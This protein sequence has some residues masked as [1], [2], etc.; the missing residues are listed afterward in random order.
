MEKTKEIV[1]IQKQS[2]TIQEFAERVAITNDEEYAEAGDKTK[3]IKL[4]GKLIK[5]QKE[6]YTLPAKQIIAEANERYSPYEKI[7]AEAERTIKNKMICYYNEQEE[8]RRKEEE[9]LAK[10]VEKGTMKETTAVRKMEQMPEQKKTIDAGRSQVQAKTRREAVIIDPSIVPK[11]YW[12][13]NESR[14]KRAALAG[15]IV[16][17][18][19]IRFVKDIAIK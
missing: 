12:D 19:E 18:V 3:D 4:L 16:P 13:L 17:G 9:V 5:E 1:E 10:R 11:E 8:K 15:A 7:C 2:T 6:K 14:A